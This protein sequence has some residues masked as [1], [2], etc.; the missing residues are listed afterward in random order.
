MFDKTT[1]CQKL[2]TI[3][4]PVPEMLSPVDVPKVAH[5]AAVIR[6]WPNAYVKLNT[7]SSAT[8][9]VVLHP[10]QGGQ[11][12]FGITT[13]A[14]IEGAFYNSARSPRDRTEPKRRGAIRSERGRDCSM[15]D[16]N[17][18]G[19]RA[20]LRHPRGDRVR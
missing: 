11:P 4:V 5:D 12:A 13:L 16:S 8:G 9:I 6:A 15:R 18:T 3:G 14:E 1:T 17:G 10:N 19:G 7:G 2:H 20:E